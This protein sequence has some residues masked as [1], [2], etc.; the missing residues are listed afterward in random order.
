MI[1]PRVRIYG[2]H[3]GFLVYAIRKERGWQ[4]ALERKERVIT[5]S[6]SLRGEFATSKLAHTRTIEFLDEIFPWKEGRRDAEI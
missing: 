6:E 4:V 2:V 5:D 1:K 3:K